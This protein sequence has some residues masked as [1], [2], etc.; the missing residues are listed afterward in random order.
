MRLGL[1][2]RHAEEPESSRARISQLH[3]PAGTKRQHSAAHS[4]K[5]AVHRGAGCPL[6]RAIVVVLQLLAQEFAQLSVS[7][8][9]RG[10]ETPGVACLRL[11]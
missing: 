7:R 8:A 1:A 11:R 2:E 6:N 10:L 4:R 3:I 5:T 9:M